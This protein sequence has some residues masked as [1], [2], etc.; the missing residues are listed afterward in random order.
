MFTYSSKL[1]A[2]YRVFRPIGDGLV[3][4]PPEYALHGIRNI[5][6]CGLLPVDGLPFEGFSH[7]F[8]SA[9]LSWD[10]RNG[11][12]L[13]SYW[14]PGENC[15]LLLLYTFLVLSTNLLL[16]TSASVIFC[17]WP[18]NCEPSFHRPIISSLW[19]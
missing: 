3:Q 14:S 11:Y 18:Q 5:F 2:I 13:H 16:V 4:V 19:I 6:L 17:F 8:S 7:R 10:R 12:L 9:I 1:L 15:K